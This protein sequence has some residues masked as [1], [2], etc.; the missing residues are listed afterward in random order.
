MGKL[1]PANSSLKEVL[2]RSMKLGESLAAEGNLKFQ[3]YK[4]MPNGLAGIHDGY[5][6][7]STVGLPPQK[8]VWKVS[9]TPV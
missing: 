8:L 2:G 6:I 1:I 7:G 3:P 9:E 5:V 4:L